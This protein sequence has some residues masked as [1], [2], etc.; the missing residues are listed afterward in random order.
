MPIKE[1][2]PLLDAFALKALINSGHRPQSII[3]AKLVNEI[4]GYSIVVFNTDYTNLSVS[5]TYLG[6]R[7]DFRN[8]GIGTE[9]LRQRIDLLKTIRVSGYQASIN[10]LVT[11]L[12]DRL[13]LEYTTSPHPQNKNL[14]MLSVRW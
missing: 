7:K 5:E 6:V 13:N 8:L 10:P 1:S 4:L 11:H 12:Y 9:I 14:L 2:Y 3:F